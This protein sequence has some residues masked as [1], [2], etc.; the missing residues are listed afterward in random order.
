MEQNKLDKISNEID[1]ELYYLKKKI[2]HRHGLTWEEARD[3]VNDTTLSLYE[4]CTQT[5]KYDV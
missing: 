5:G 4:G 1:D 2:Q 3:I